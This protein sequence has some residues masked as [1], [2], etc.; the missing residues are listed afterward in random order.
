[1]KSNEIFFFFTPDDSGKPT[2]P[3][4]SKTP[5][6]A[7]SDPI[8]TDAT[9]SDTNTK[10]SSPPVLSAAEDNTLDTISTLAPSTLVADVMDAPP[11]P[12][13]PTP[14][15]QSAP[16]VPAYPAPLPDPVPTSAAQDKMDKKATEVME[17]EEEVVV[18]EDEAVVEEAVL[19]SDTSLAPSSTAN[20][21]TDVEPERLSV[22]LPL[23]QLEAPLESP[24][25]Q[26]EELRLPNGLPLPAPQDPE[27]PIVNL[28]EHDDSPIAEPD[29]S[30][31]PTIH[32]SAATIHAAPTPVVQAVPA[33]VDQPGPAATVQ[34]IPS[35]PV[36]YAA[37]TQLAVKDTV[38]PVALDV[39]DETPV[40]QSAAEEEKPS[41]AETVSIAD[42]AP[43]TVPTP[44]P[45]TAE[46]RE[47]TPP[48]QMVTPAL[49]E[50][51]MQGQ[52]MTTQ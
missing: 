42:S 12:R 40:P 49:V 17:E 20:G 3:P 6:L 37:P 26:P 41:P 11:P 7:K 9:S 1:M 46:E 34:E 29:I 23:S 43:E 24:I 27:V 10:P 28:A 4:L 13:E 47:D 50:T 16:E 45:S 44:P 15:P 35:D 2:P 48:P 31:Q 8:P 32:T 51:T 22:V 14:P 21:V 18:K 33:A 19:S 38:P 39:K 30:Q 5:E 52:L 36:V 25:A